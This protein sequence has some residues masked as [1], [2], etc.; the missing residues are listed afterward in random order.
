M[1]VPEF[2]RRAAQQRAAD[3]D[4]P[5]RKKLRP[6]ARTRPAL[7]VGHGADAAER[8][9]DRI[10]DGVIS[11]LMAA[12]Q[13]SQRVDGSIL[14]SATGPAAAALVGYEGGPLP[15]HV[16]DRIDRARAGGSS[17]P[18]DTRS[19]MKGAFG[20]DLGQVRVHHDGEAAT[21]NRIVSAQAFTS[22]RDI[23]FGAGQYRPDTQAGERLLAHELAHTQQDSGVRRSTIRRWN[24]NAPTLDWSKTQSIGTVTSGQ[25]VWFFDDSTGD[26]IVV[27]KEDRQVGLGELSAL[28]HET[29]S[30]VQSV[31]HRK[32]G[33]GDRKIV[34]NFLTDNSGAKLDRASWTALG[35]EQRATPNFEEAL[36]DELGDGLDKMSDFEVGRYVHSSAMAKSSLPLVAMTYAAGET[37]KTAAGKKDIDTTGQRQ[38]AQLQQSRLRGLMTDIKHVEALGQ[39]TAVDL[40]LGNK[41]RVLYGNLGNWIYDPMSAAMTAIDHV[42]GEVSANFQKDSQTKSDLR[43]LLKPLAVGEL[44]KTAK[45]AVSGV[46]SGARVF[47]KDDGFAAWL[48]SDRGYHRANA[49]EAMQAGLEKGRK[50]VLKTFMA[51]RFS[52]SSKGRAVK[53]AIK[54]ASRAAMAVDSD[55]ATDDAS[56]YYKVL[57]ARALYLSKN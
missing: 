34:T 21:L 48:D 47:A 46:A 25:A 44:G 7:V 38:G 8:H 26:R 56:Y 37:A 57:K 9:A 2:D 23:F 52:G 20:A 18:T 35:A 27:K 13:G 14:R 11:R 45:A 43:V 54:S 33:S 19:R 53:K 36:R 6:P 41:D 1:P 5:V 4:S 39:M 24:I 30:N 15:D 32:L 17:L 3:L 16:S 31:R 49:E 28:M 42:D 29:I 40:F 51:T 55:D 50:L 22:G 10:A 12:G